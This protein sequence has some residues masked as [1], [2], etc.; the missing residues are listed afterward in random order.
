MYRLILY[1]FIYFSSCKKYRTTFAMSIGCVCGLFAQLTFLRQERHLGFRSIYPSCSNTLQIIFLSEKCIY[2]NNISQMS[3]SE[4]MDIAIGRS[5]QLYQLC[6]GVSQCIIGTK[7]ISYC[8]MLPCCGLIS[9]EVPRS[10]PFTVLLSRH[11]FSMA[12]C[13]AFSVLETCRVKVGDEFQN[14]NVYP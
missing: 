13:V 11:L 8:S 6:G 4:F 3:I 9:S 14:S 2:V 10:M 7:I 5:V 12:S 1:S